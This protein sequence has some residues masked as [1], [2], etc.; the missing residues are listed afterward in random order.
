MTIPIV[1]TKW[2][3]RPNSGLQSVANPEIE[4]QKPTLQFGE[5]VFLRIKCLT[6]FADFSSGRAELFLSCFWAVLHRRS[7]LHASVE[8]NLV[9]VLDMAEIDESER[10]QLMTAILAILPEVPETFHSFVMMRSLKCLQQMN[11]VSSKDLSCLRMILLGER[12][13]ESF[14]VP[15][16]VADEIIRIGVGMWA[17]AD[18]QEWDQLLAETI[19]L[20]V[21]RAQAGGEEWRWFQNSL[22]RLVA[23]N[24][25]LGRHAAPHEV[26]ERSSNRTTL[27]GQKP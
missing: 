18:R 21:L 1:T 26:V 5:L 3:S 14:T 6:G 10:L 13:S 8:G 25:G 11:R 24:L 27:K 2:I 12:N 20:H 7:A 17:R 23:A 16:G 22:M 9:S 19:A 15:R 4:I